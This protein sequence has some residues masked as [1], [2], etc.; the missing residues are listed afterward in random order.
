MSD[1]SMDKKELLGFLAQ[2]KESSSHRA[3]KEQSTNHKIY[4]VAISNSHIVLV[5]EDE[6]N[7]C[8]SPRRHARAVANP[9]YLIMSNILSNVLCRNMLYVM[10]LHVEA[11]KLFSRS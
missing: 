5:D 4:Q 8:T 9:E 6:E 3:F 11:A 2:E 7:P 10:E 1:G